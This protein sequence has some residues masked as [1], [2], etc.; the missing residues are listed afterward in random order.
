M[1]PLSS[2][3]QGRPSK[4]TNADQLTRT[5]GH[6]RTDGRQRAKA[7]LRSW[8]LHC[9]LLLNDLFFPGV[10]RG[11]HIQM[12]A[13]VFFASDRTADTYKYLP[14]YLHFLPC[15]TTIQ[16]ECEDNVQ[17]EVAVQVEVE[18]TVDSTGRAGGELSNSHKRVYVQQRRKGK[19]G[20]APAGSIGPTWNMR[21]WMYMTRRNTPE[22]R[23]TA[24]RLAFSCRANINRKG[25]GQDG[26][27]MRARPG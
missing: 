25:S 16:V 20:A 17:V 7:R 26:R 8:R 24:S 27:Q 3:R 1:Q 21:S 19:Q 13:G 15:T 18:V 10:D 12:S 2:S 11:A 22:K 4:T 6:R 9:Y 14:T 23:E 5:A